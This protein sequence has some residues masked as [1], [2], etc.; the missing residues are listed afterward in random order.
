VT[1]NVLAVAQALKAVVAELEGI[2]TDQTNTKQVFV[3]INTAWPSTPAAEVI[4]VA[5]DLQTL[6]AGAN[7]QLVTGVFYVAFYVAVTPNL[8]ADEL[9]LLPLCA[10]LVDALAD[11][12]FDYTLG[13]LVEDC[14]AV[15]AEFDIVKRTGRSYRSAVVQVVVG[16]LDDSV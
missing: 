15:R 7:E 16:E 11:E 4:P 5:V 14:R 6:A 8:E 12:D 1:V 3:G 10:A 9:T 2:A 13:G